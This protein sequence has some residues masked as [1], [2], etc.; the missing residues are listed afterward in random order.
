MIQ[1]PKKPLTKLRVTACDL[2]TTLEDLTLESSSGLS[3]LM[4][5]TELTI[6]DCESLTSLSGLPQLPSL[7]KLSLDGCKS[8]T[9]LL[10][11]PYLPSL[12]RLDLDGCKSLAS[13]SVLSQLPSLEK[14]YL[15][16][17]ESLTG[18]S[19]LPQLLSLEGL[20]FLGCKSL[21]SLSGMPQLPSLKGLNLAGCE[22]LTSLSGMPQLPSLKGL[23]L[24][25]CVALRN[26]DVLSE[27]T[28]L[29]KIRYNID[30]P[31]ADS[32]LALCAVK[33]G[34]ADFIAAN[35]KEWLKG[36]LVSKNPD[37][38]AWRMIKAVKLGVGEPWFTESLK[39]ICS[40]CLE[41]RED[42]S[43]D[44]WSLLFGAMLEIAERDF[45]D[46]FETVVRKYPP[47]KYTSTML[48]PWLEALSRVLP[49]E[50]DWA[51]NLV[52]EVLATI[53]NLSISLEVVPSICL[54]YLRHGKNSQ[55]QEWL[56]R[57]TK[58]ESPVWRDRCL[59]IMMRYELH[60]GDPGRA[61]EFL[62]G[63]NECTVK[64]EAL[65]EMALFLVQTDPE[66]AG[67]NLEA[68]SDR[69]KQMGVAEKLAGFPQFN[70]S[71]INIYR[72]LFI[73]G[74]N[75]GRLVAFLSKLQL[76]DTQLSVLGEFSRQLLSTSDIDEDLL[77]LFQKL[78]DSR[79]VADFANRR[80]LYQFKEQLL[81]DQRGLKHCLLEGL[82]AVMVTEKVLSVNGRSE[83]LAEFHGKPM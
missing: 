59:H 37:Q 5:L 44:T 17:S 47:E 83:L 16:G 12:K 33:R 3:H 63:I 18:L 19:G 68:I 81:G 67:E 9:S 11:L 10:G 77:S 28:N 4:S 45:Q 6:I 32:I 25:G 42:I 78:L 66:G 72:L 1:D 2:F 23:N 31:L 39:I 55:V 62:Q 82:T 22:S 76:Q 40:G 13:L 34:D 53:M 71:L 7:E 60:H 24:D 15:G 61:R 70:Q 36:F 14:L 79:T 38:F 50:Q 65:A 56:A 35:I 30:Q 57:A 69:I 73:L 74:K 54:F 27:Q 64:D 20:V 21:T 46:L 41:L 48:A 75:P 52:D 58:P 49:E 51:V 43:A 26:I 29:E 80:E 8:L